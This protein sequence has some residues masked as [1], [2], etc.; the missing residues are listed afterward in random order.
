MQ[1]VA[2][3]LLSVSLS[4]ITFSAAHTNALIETVLPA[5]KPY[6]SAVNEEY[7]AT[8]TAP[9]PSDTAFEDY[10]TRRTM[11]TSTVPTGSAA[12]TSDAATNSPSGNYTVIV[13]GTVTTTVPCDVLTT[14][15][16]NGQT[17]VISG[18]HT[19]TVPCPKCQGSQAIPTAHHDVPEGYTVVVSGTVTMTV[20]C[21]SQSQGSHVIASGSSSKPSQGSNGSNG[22]GPSGSSSGSPGSGSG[23]GDSS[24]NNGSGSGA[25]PTTIVV[26]PS[27]GSSSHDGTSTET[28]AVIVNGVAKAGSIGLGAILALGALLV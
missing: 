9:L 22:A 3:M 18:T 27:T 2:M 10:K 4:A 6:C 8:A 12:Q 21:S 1:P 19:V 28:P 11:V 15:M 26:V 17:V 7:L 13:S 14:T 16:P 25:N 20:P 23:S 24:S 5:A